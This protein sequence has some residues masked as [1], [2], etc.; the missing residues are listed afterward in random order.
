MWQYVIRFSRVFPPLLRLTSYQHTNFALAVISGD[1]FLADIEVPLH[2]QR[3]FWVKTLKLEASSWI[4]GR[5]FYPL[6]IRAAIKKRIFLFDDV[7]AHLR[8][9]SR[10]GAGYIL[11]NCE[12]L[13]ALQSA[14]VWLF[15]PR[16][17]SRSQ[18]AWNRTIRSSSFIYIA[19][20]HKKMYY[21]LSVQ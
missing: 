7:F 21:R 10:T 6:A 17:S 16:A 5:F 4:S 13:V 9:S 20:L 11:Y 2:Y 8:I 15:M 19:K 18:S 1:A 3:K 14:C 12:R